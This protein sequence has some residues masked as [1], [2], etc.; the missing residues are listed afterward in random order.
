M[1][2]DPYQT[3]RRERMAA[4]LVRNSIPDDILDELV[5]ASRDPYYFG[6][7]HPEGGSGEEA[8]LDD[9]NSEVWSNLD[10]LIMDDEGVFIS[11]D[12]WNDF[13]KARDDHPRKDE[14]KSQY[15][16]RSGGFISANQIFDWAKK[17]CLQERMLANDNTQSDNRR[18]G[19]AAYNGEESLHP[20]S[21]AERASS[22]SYHNE[23]HWDK[24]DKSQSTIIYYALFWRYTC[25]WRYR[26][27]FYNSFLLR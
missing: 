3:T 10:G 21:D 20:N 15:S 9:A 26:Y 11:A 5:E 16:R 27:C 23:D 1:S 17:L 25:H 12:T 7:R 6:R 22:R 13:Q 4:V 8:V 19:D 14:A 2:K 24:V 18:W